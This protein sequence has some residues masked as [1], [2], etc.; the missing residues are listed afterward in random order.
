MDKKQQKKGIALQS[1]RSS[2]E[3]AYRLFARKMASKVT[4][5]DKREKVDDLISS[6]KNS[7][8]Y[9]KL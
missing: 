9:D 8:Y 5:N 6:L 1:N 4:L 3:R 2:N 7:E